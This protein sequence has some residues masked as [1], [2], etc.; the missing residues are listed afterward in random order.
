MAR[1]ADRKPAHVATERQQE[2]ELEVQDERGWGGQHGQHPANAE[3][4]Q[5][6][7]RKGSSDSQPD[8]NGD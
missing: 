6:R 8:E 4:K 5:Y 1:R 7:P 2:N 3:E